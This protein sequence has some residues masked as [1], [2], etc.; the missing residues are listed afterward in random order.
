MHGR[1][2]L[3]LQTG[4]V[5]LITGGPFSTATGLLISSVASYFILGGGGGGGQDSQMYQQKKKITLRYKRERANTSQKYVHVSKYLLYLHKN[6]MTL[7]M[8]K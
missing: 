7:L 3:G 6:G 1:G 2:G 4:R 8:I 5:F